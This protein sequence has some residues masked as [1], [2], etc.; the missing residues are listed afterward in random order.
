VEGTVIFQSAH[1]LIALRFKEGLPRAVSWGG[2]SFAPDKDGYNWLPV[3]A[4]RELTESH[5]MEGVPG[6]PVVEAAPERFRPASL[7]GIAAIE[8]ELA[9]GVTIVTPTAGGGAIRPAVFPPEGEHPDGGPQPALGPP[10]TE[11]EVLA[12]AS[13]PVASAKPSKK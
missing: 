8:H 12:S 6:V 2:M 5:G 10:P 13:E 7:A 11:A 4:V 9:P 1:P 3:E